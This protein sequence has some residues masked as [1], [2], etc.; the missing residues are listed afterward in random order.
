MTHI[1]YILKIS[2]TKHNVVTDQKFIIYRRKLKLYI[3]AVCVSS[4]WISWF[5]IAETVEVPL[6][7]L[8]VPTAS[9]SVF[10]PAVVLTLSKTLKYQLSLSDLRLRILLGL[11]TWKR[12]AFSLHKLQNR[13]SIYMVLK[14]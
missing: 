9:R 4:L 2:V 12:I 6:L 8:S 1:S 10:L 14:F 5:L 7:C 13:Q 3:A 11:H